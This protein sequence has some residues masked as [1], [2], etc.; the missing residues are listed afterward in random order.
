MS[1]LDLQHLVTHCGM[2]LRKIAE[3]KDWQTPEM[4][5]LQNLFGEFAAGGRTSVNNLRLLITCVGRRD[6]DG[7]ALQA[8][9]NEDAQHFWRGYYGAEP[10][11]NAGRISTGV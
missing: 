8:L 2:R 7:A 1:T 4:G 5:P 6:A 9:T 3:S 11:M 10:S